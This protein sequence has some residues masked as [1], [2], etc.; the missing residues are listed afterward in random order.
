MEGK[1]K[2]EKTP[3]PAPIPTNSVVALP[4]TQV[5]LSLLVPV[6]PVA[7]MGEDRDVVLTR[8]VRPPSPFPMAPTLPVAPPYTY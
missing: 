6:P 2:K 4:Y 5:P 7:P 8:R 3:S 1:T